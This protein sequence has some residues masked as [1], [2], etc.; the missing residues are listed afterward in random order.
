[1]ETK[2][3]IFTKYKKEYAGAAKERKGTILDMALWIT[4]LLPR[5]C[6]KNKKPLNSFLFNG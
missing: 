6:C 4:K 5:L 1:M 3:E 2:N